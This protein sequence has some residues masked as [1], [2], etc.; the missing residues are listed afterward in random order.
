[1]ILAA[2]VLGAVATAGGQGRPSAAGVEPNA[3]L[4]PLGWLAGGR[5]VAASNSPQA[6]NLMRETI[7]EWAPNGQ[8]LRFWSF[9]TDRQL[10]R[11]PYVDGWYAFHPGRKALIF[12]YVDAE[13]Y[14]EGTVRVAG[15]TVAHEFEGI[16]T[17]G[18]VQRY[19][20]TFT[21]RS[22]DEMG[23]RISEEV[24]GGWRD[25]IELV[26]RRQPF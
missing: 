5:W 23:V 9:V 16:S 6:P 4:A 8:A 3:A 2:A 24:Q 7:F 15:D 11:R 18:D 21:R 14:Y 13:G 20:Y 10:Q 12:S 17:T 19:R 26:Y 1:M 22:A 25:V